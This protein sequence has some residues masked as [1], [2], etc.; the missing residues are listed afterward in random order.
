MLFKADTLA[1]IATGE[2]TAAFH[3]GARPTVKAGG[4]LRTAAGVLAI[5][6]V[7]EIDPGAI[8]Q[9]DA[10]RAGFPELAAL[11]KE[12]ARR[13]E[14]LCYRIEFHLAGA[15]PRIALREQADLRGADLAALPAALAALDRHAERPWTAMA[16][17]LIG[18]RDGTT[19]AELAGRLGLDKP[20]LKQRIR[21]LKELGQTESLEVGYRLSPRGRSTLARMETPG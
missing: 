16:L 15:D 2:V 1:R 3:R 11:R 10:A 21:K 6:R 20:L 4:T 19:A 9:A 18:L 5:D 8:D 12:L 14:G 13:P 17:H 7:S